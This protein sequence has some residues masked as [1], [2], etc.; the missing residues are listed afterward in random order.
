MDR[1]VSDLLDSSRIE[2]G[3][4]ELRLDTRDLRDVVLRV[5]ELQ[6]DSRTDRRFVLSVCE[7]PV[8]VRCDVLRIEQVLNNLLNN[9]V[10]YSPEASD[11]LV[12]L[13]ATR[14]FARLSV[15]DHGAGI[16]MSDRER[17]FAPFSRGA[18]VGA[19]AGVGLGLSVSRRI[20]VA[21]GGTIDVDS[22]PGA[23][24][25][26]TVELPL[27]GVPPAPPAGSDPAASRHTAAG[28]KV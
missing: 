13:S 27:A 16:P 19:I 3:Q 7:A 17:I 11:V 22:T 21:H 14:E 5:V 26:F 24:S 20:V 12:M 8:P 1:M 9:A 4:L 28:V 6:Q 10:K 23:G 2:S 15:T 18:N 25:T